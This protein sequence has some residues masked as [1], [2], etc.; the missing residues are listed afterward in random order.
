MNVILIICSCSF[1]TDEDVATVLLGGGEEIDI[2]PFGEAELAAQGGHGG[3][4][5]ADGEV[6]LAEVADECLE[7]A[8]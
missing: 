5:V 4:E 7:I 1:A 8:L 3:R 2:A 6:G